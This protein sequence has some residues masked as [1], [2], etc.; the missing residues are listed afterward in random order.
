ME[1]STAIYIAKE[2]MS[3]FRMRAIKGGTILAGG[4]AKRYDIEQVILSSSPNHLY[5]VSVAN[6]EVVCRY[7][8]AVYTANRLI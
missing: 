8:G 5:A 4:C 6:W 1:R 7:N 2:A 3:L